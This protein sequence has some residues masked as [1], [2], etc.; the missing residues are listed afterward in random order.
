MT[1]RRLLLDDDSEDTID[2]Y[3]SEYG[4]I[5]RKQEINR[6]K[7]RQVV[8]NIW[9]SSNSKRCHFCPCRSDSSESNQ[10]H[11]LE[12]KNMTDE[13]KRYRLK[14]LWFRVRCVLNM[15]RFIIILKTNLSIADDDRE[16]GLKFEML[17]EDD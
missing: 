10:N 13:Q 5:Q 7:N 17:M 2:D 9:Q 4:E 11:T 15:I 3:K 8:D 14:Y 16:N 12:F 6:I 1:K